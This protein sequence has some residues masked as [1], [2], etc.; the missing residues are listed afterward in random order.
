[1]VLQYALRG[2]FVEANEVVDKIK[3][4]SSRNLKQSQVV[5]QYS[6]IIRLKQAILR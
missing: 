5:A 6:K 4:A 1:M 2:A 3:K